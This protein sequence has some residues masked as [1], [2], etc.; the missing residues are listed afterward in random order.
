[1]KRILA[2]VAALVGVLAFGTPSHAALITYDLTGTSSVQ[3]VSQFAPVPPGYFTT[4]FS[5]GSYM[6]INTDANGDLVEGDVSNFGG[7]FNIIGTTP[8]GALGSIS[9][10]VVVTAYGGG[11]TLSGS[12]ILWSTPVGLNSTGTFSCAGAICGIFGLTP[13]APYP[14]AGL[15]ALTGAVPV[16]PVD[17]GT[18]TLA[19]D[20]SSILSS[21]NAVITLGG[22]TP[23]PGPGLPSQWYT[24]AGPQLVPEPGVLALMVLGLGALALRRRA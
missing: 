9:T 19:G 23:P 15:A 21:T 10:D 13:G 22:P 18:W 24:F 14:I 20:L 7:V 6:T 8:L 1:M 11:G 3:T 5:A 12:Q 17:F 2:T 16:N 4:L